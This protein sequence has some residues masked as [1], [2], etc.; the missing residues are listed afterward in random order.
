MNHVYVD[1]L[2]DAVLLLLRRGKS[3]E[4]YNVTDGYNTTFVEFYS[5]LCYVCLGHRRVFAIPKFLFKVAFLVLFL[6]M[7][8]TKLVGF[9]FGKGLNFSLTAAE[10]L[11]RP[12]P[13]SI[14]KIKK[15]GYRP[16]VSLDKG[17]KNVQRWMKEKELLD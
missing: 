4:A 16:K 1:N 15:L 3:G 11:S 13:Y 5:K 9:E 14:K 17:M 6:V 12:Y 7:F 10:F 8:F 2:I